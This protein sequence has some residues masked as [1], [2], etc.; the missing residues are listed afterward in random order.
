VARKGSGEGLERKII[1][2]CY[3]K[4]NQK[5]EKEEGGGVEEGV[6]RSFPWKVGILMQG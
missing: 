2:M 5:S 6:C 4:V 3:V 1:N